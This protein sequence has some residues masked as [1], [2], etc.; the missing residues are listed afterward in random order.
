[1]TK[2]TRERNR[3]KL[4]KDII[5][6][7]SEFNERAIKVKISYQKVPL[8]DKKNLYTIY[9]LTKAFKLDF[10]KIVQ[11]SLK[12][13]M[14]RLISEISKNLNIYDFELSVRIHY[15]YNFQNKKHYF[16]VN[17][18]LMHDDI[19]IGSFILNNMSENEMLHTHISY[20]SSLINTGF[21]ELIEFSKKIN[22][23]KLSDVYISLVSDGNFEKNK[24]NDIIEKSKLM[25]IDNKIKN[26]IKKF[27]I[28]DNLIPLVNNRINSIKIHYYIGL[29]SKF[30]LVFHKKLDFEFLKGGPNY[31]KSFFHY[32]DDI[33][34]ETMIKILVESKILPSDII[35]DEKQMTD[36][37]LY[38][39]FQQAR[40]L[41]Y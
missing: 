28:D 12:S 3:V 19:R 5:S 36:E 26:K 29:K 25:N 6:G 11:P 31:S 14:P 37:Y 22:Q 4:V 39:I 10:Q 2:S 1:M 40:L 21:K 35:Y 15:G 33:T 32:C 8:S 17:F 13:N 34:N 27:Q 16:T 9:T 23:I 18:H 24:I 20:K 38:A 7:K 30:S 41:N